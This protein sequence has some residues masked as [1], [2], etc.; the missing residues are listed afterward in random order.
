MHKNINE[1]N[2]TSYRY[3]YKIRNILNIHPQ[4]KFNMKTIFRICCCIVLILSTMSCSKDDPVSGTFKA[5][6][7]FC[8]YFSPQTITYESYGE[9]SKIVLDNKEKITKEGNPT[10]FLNLSKMYG[11]TGQKEFWTSQPPC[12]KPYGI[13]SIKV[14]QITNGERT[15]ISDNVT[16]AYTDCSNIIRSN[17][18]DMNEQDVKKKLSELTPHDL[19]WILKEFILFHSSSKEE[20]FYLVI[21]LDNGKEISQEISF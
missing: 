6:Y 9:R 10:D 20:K 19:K 14:Y 13:S 4:T 21:T 7:L 18:T 8:S 11:E 17:Y 1:P 16:V 3:R 5:R 12:I 2:D 15:D